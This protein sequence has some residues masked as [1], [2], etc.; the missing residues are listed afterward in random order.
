M[1]SAFVSMWTESHKICKV[2]ALINQVL[3][4][5]FR[6]YVLWLNKS[7]HRVKQVD[8]GESTDINQSIS[9]NRFYPIETLSFIR[10]L[11]LF[12]HNHHNSVFS[13][14]VRRVCYSHN[15]KAWHL[16]CS[17]LKLLMVIQQLKRNFDLANNL[18]MVI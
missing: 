17:I 6:S 7:N 9:M 15:W 11:F 1:L 8:I 18:A 3:P 16:C 5:C 12:S 10:E 13:T 4:Q 14:H 2:W